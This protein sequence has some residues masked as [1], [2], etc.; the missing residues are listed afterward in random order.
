MMGGRRM[1]TRRSVLGL[2]ASP[3]ASAGDAAG[4]TLPPGP[5]RL[6]VPF[7]PGGPTDA[8]TRILADEV[9]Q[10]LRRPVVI[11]NRPGASGTLGTRAALSAPPD[12]K[13]LLIGNNQTQATAP[14]L[15]R[16]A[17]YNPRTD[18]QPIVGLADMHHVLVVRKGLDISSV[19]GLIDKA[20]GAAGRLNY[21]STG[22]GSGS[23]LAMELFMLRTS[24]RMQHV[25]FTGAAQ[26]IGEMAAGRLDVALAV[27]PTVVGQVA[28]GSIV[29]LATAARVR[30]PQLPHVPTLMQTG[31][32]GAEAES[33]LALFAHAHV[34]DALAALMGARFR[35]LLIR[36]SVRARIEALGLSLAP[37]T[38]DEFRVFQAREIA[39]WG[40]VIALAG[41]KPE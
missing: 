19:S 21:G 7:P 10:D 36:P 18:L 41:L 1:P 20:K 22:V 5:L 26:L 12:G 4:Q 25:P 37:R 29:A 6:I 13:T 38:A 27:L 39:R 9:R 8:V 33:W 35:R 30:A 3:F 32:A 34:P 17:G 16:D 23:H 31:I 14:F 15:I 24:T 28:A 11:Q 40:E 2:A